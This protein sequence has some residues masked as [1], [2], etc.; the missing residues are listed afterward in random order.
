MSERTAPDWGAAA[1]EW[2][3]LWADID[4]PAREVI[5]EASGIGEVRG[6]GPAARAGVRYLIA[7]A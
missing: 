2:A 1:A 6:H 4:V 7:V 3:E 5:A